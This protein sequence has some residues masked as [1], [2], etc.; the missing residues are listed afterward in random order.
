[1]TKFEGAHNFRGLRKV[2]GNR[3]GLPRCLLTA[4][5]KR[6]RELAQAHE[7]TKMSD[8]KSSPRHDEDVPEDHRRQT[9]T[10]RM[11]M[12]F[13]NYLESA[14]QEEFPESIHYAGNTLP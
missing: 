4:L 1:V 3:A 6:L 7:T 2:Y 12:R 5:I 14:P 10:P 11:T 9:A 13:A 8:S